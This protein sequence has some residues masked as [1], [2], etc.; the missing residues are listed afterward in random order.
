MVLNELKIGQKVYFEDTPLVVSDLLDSWLWKRADFPEVEC[1]WIDK[2]GVQ[3]T[4]FFKEAVLRCEQLRI[5]K[6]IVSLPLLYSE[7]VGCYGW[8]EYAS[9]IASNFAQKEEGT[10]REDRQTRFVYDFKKFGKHGEEIRDYFEL[11]KVYFGVGTV[12]V[13]PSHVPVVNELQKLVGVRVF[14]RVLESVPRKYNH[15]IDLAEDYESTYKVHWDLLKEK[16]V[17]VVDDVVT[18]GVTINHFAGVL[19]ARGYEVIRFGLGLNNKL[20]FKEAY[21][22]FMKV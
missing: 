2:A 8:K 7:K 16:R 1:S 6:S 14:E 10:E 4:K 9:L 19:E 5:A 13:V 17:L 3:H 12:A 22:F 20:P 11:L 21:R 18:S 15:R